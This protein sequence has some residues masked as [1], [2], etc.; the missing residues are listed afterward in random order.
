[1]HDELHSDELKVSASMK[2]LRQPVAA[3]IFMKAVDQLLLTVQV[4]THPKA[5][6]L[7]PWVLS[8]HNSTIYHI[9]NPTNKLTT[10]TVLI[11]MQHVKSVYDW[12]HRLG[13]Q[14]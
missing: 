6:H 7:Y 8:P 1:M 9:Q 14:S 4:V 2:Y 10:S 5:R 13:D 12:N 11:N 3:L